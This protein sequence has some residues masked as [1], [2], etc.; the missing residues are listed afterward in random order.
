ME[1]A[2]RNAMHYASVAVRAWSWG[3]MLLV[4]GFGGARTSARFLDLER[5]VFSREK[6]IR[7]SVMSHVKQPQTLCEHRR[8]HHRIKPTQGACG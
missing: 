7:M 2:H 5:K 3:L 4:G 8:N 6:A 1:V